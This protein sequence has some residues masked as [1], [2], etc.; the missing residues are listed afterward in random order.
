MSAAELVFL[1]T[2][3]AVGVAV[4]RAASEEGRPRRFGLGAW[5]L[6]SGALAH[7]GWLAQ[8]DARPP[9]F[10][11]FMSATFALTLA[12]AF[13][14]AGA[15]AAE[16]VGWAGLLGFQAFR[17]PVE[18]VLFQ[19]HRE[20]VVPVQMTFEGRNFDILAGASAPLVAW[21]AATGRIGRRGILVWTCAALATLANIVTIAVLSTPTPLRAFANEPANTFVTRL[22]W[23]W[24]PG[25]LVPAALLGH[26]LTFRKL[27]RMR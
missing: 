11:V 3:V 13:S 2:V 10:F 24:L 26:L 7:S 23:V 16:R 14:R 12:L 17:L 1:L 9:H 15:R 22:P 4:G 25:F 5:L 20:G 21:L 27:A 8:F 19:L 6:L 18:W